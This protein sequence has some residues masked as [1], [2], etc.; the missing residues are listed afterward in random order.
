MSIFVL[1]CF[2]Y[3][4]E[5]TRFLFAKTKRVRRLFQYVL[6]ITH[7]KDIFPQRGLN[8]A[9]LSFCAAKLHKIFDIRKFFQIFMKKICTFDADF[10]ILR[11]IA[12]SKG[13][14]R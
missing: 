1:H 3:H 6:Y 13:R 4:Y 9:K 7:P 12:D 8:T 5:F 2:G 11:S 14:G 10:L